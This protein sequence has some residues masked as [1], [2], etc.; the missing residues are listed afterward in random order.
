[1]LLGGDSPIPHEVVLEDLNVDFVVDIN[2]LLF[3]IAVWGDCLDDMVSDVTGACCRSSSFC[4]NIREV[5][6][7][8]LSG[9]YIGDN[10]LCE[11]VD[12]QNP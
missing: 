8:V 7:G 5:A 6:C 9:Q 3:L 10:T 2:D 12:C 4:V 11:D 1:M